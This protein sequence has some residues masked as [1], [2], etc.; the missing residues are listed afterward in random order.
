MLDEDAA[1][2]ATADFQA[3]ICMTA[4]RTSTQPLPSLNHQQLFVDIQN[5]NEYAHLMSPNGHDKELQQSGH[6]RHAPKLRGY[7][8][9][10]DFIASDSDA[11][12]FR[13]YKSMSARN[14]LYLQSEIHELEKQLQ[15]LDSED[16]KASSFEAEGA[17]QLWRHYNSNA[18]ARAVEHRKLQREIR[19]K[20][21]EY[22]KSRRTPM[23]SS[24]PLMIPQMRPSFSNPKSSHSRNPRHGPSKHSSSGSNPIPSALYS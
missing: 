9:F 17:A 13:T 6:G 11:A 10:A 2:C 14:L 23:T 19:E 3:P 12:I 22:R 24:W 8:T 20:L 18:N 5:T 7:P 1:S 15:E 16:V 4:S 21:K